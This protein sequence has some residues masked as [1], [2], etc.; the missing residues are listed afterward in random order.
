MKAFVA[1]RACPPWQQG[2]V[3]QPGPFDEEQA[4]LTAFVRVKGR[5]SG[6]RRTGV[7]IEGWRYPPDSAVAVRSFLKLVEFVLLDPV[8]RIDHN[9]V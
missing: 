1:M 9:G 4:K 3:D 5:E 2:A 8:G 6:Q 7:T